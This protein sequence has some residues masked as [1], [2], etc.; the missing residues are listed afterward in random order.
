[1]V[2]IGSHFFVKTY[3]IKCITLVKIIL[4]EYKINCYLIAIYIIKH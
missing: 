2:N 4:V 3:L 1:M